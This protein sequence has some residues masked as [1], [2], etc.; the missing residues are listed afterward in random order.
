LRA[1]VWRGLLGLKV[2]WS[3]VRVIMGGFWLRGGKEVELF[4]KVQL[5]ASG[6]GGAKKL[7]FLKKFNFWLL[8]SGYSS[9]S[10]GYGPL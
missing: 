9:K 4:G 1:I 3:L 5:L 2:T 10:E 6:Y 7:N 8:A